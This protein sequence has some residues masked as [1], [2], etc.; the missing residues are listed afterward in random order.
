LHHLDD[1][2]SSNDNTTEFG[3]E[4]DEEDAQFSLTMQENDVASKDD[5]K[6]QGLNHLLQ[7]KSAN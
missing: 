1:E 2:G 6:D 3:S 7:Q 5:P 4:N